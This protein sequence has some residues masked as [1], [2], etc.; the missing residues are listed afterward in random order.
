MKVYP[1]TRTAVHNFQI[2]ADKRFCV[3]NGTP[4]RCE[5]RDI[6]FPKVWKVEDHPLVHGSY[7]ETIWVILV[8]TSD[9]GRAAAS[10]FE[11]TLTTPLGPDALMKEFGRHL[12]NG[13]QTL[14]T[15]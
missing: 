4:V 10:K 11:S 14:L 8:D 9:E 1:S 12:S 5:N 13:S 3:K 6:R 7:T 15:A 2:P